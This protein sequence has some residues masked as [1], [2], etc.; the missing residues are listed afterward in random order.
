MVS[1]STS[2]RFPLDYLGRNVKSLKKGSEAYQY[3]V[4]NLTWSGLY[5]GSNF[6]N[7]LLQKVLALVPLRETGP[8]VFVTTM[9]KF[10]YNS[11]D[12]L[13]ETLNPMKSLKTISYPR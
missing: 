2:V 3:V 12:V 11:Y 5:L 9:N 10:L 4:Q 13:Y 7:T 6:S 8:E 1:S